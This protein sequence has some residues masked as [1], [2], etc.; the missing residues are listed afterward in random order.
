MIIEV[1]FFVGGRTQA[2]L[3]GA[4]VAMTCLPEKLNPVI[5]PI[6]ESLKREECEIFQK[7]SAMYLVKLLDQ[8]AVRQPCPNNKIVTNLCTLLKS[9]A[10]FTPKIVSNFLSN[11]CAYFNLFLLFLIT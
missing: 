4:T 1:I 2:V 10:D 9:D 3:A 6:M 7:N 5:K 11:F 8:V